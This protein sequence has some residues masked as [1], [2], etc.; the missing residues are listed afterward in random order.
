LEDESTSADMPQVDSIPS[1]HF[2]ETLA[3]SLIP[4]NNRQLQ[5]GQTKEEWKGQLE[6]NKL[7]GNQ[8]IVPIDGHCVRIGAMRCHSQA[9]TLKLRKDVPLDE[10]EDIIARANDW[11]KVVPNTRE[12]SMTDLTP[13]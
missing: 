5:S 2:S 10:I 1:A 9:I 3:G 11:S 4:Y 7:L 12:A 6:T 13:V 8:Q